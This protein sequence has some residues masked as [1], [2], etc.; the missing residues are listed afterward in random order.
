MAVILVEKE[1]IGDPTFDKLKLWVIPVTI[2]AK[3]RNHTFNLLL[4]TGAQQTVIIPAVKKIMGLEVDS[5]SV[6]ASGV[7]GK[8]EYSTATVNL[9]IGA[10]QF[11]NLNI[12]VGSLP[13]MFSKYQIAG[14]LG[15]DVLQLI[16]LKIDYPKKHLKIK[17]AFVYS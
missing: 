10:I 2:N 12:L 6:K 13:G 8:A 5:E 1:F 17:R 3:E 11:L 4:D 14:I 15:A 9:E 16:V 7:T